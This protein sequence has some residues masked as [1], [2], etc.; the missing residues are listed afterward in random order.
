MKRSFDF[1]AWNR[2]RL[3]FSE[4]WQRPWLLEVLNIQYFTEN[5]HKIIS[6]IYYCSV[7]FGFVGLFTQ[8]SCLLAFFLG[9]YYL[10]LRHGLKLHHSVMPVHFIMLA[11]A[12]GPSGKVFSIDSILNLHFVEFLK[13]DGAESWSINFIK[14]VFSIVIF[15]TGVAKI[16]HVRGHEGFLSKQNLATIIRMHDF[17]Y[18]YAFPLFSISKY[19]LRYRWVEKLASLGTVFIE[20]I[21]PLAVI[22]P[23]TSFL[24]VP[25]MIF[26]I[27]GFRL[28]MGPPFDFFNIC[29]IATFFPWD[30]IYN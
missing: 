17:P 18:F 2:A 16:R 14:V 26:L 5:V 21:F 19:L 24:I 13:I 15:A 23:S 6:R 29:L 1:N 30:I 25:A 27:V 9:L 11:F 20:L 8:P 10:G 7:F 4:Y 12:L 3:A 22:F 28:F